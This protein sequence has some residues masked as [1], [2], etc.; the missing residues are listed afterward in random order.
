MRTFCLSPFVA[1]FFRFFAFAAG[2]LFCLAF[3]DA[4]HYRRFRTVPVYFRELIQAVTTSSARMCFTFT[5]FCTIYPSSQS[6]CHSFSEACSTPPNNCR[7]K[8]FRTF[9]YCINTY[10]CVARTC[11]RVCVRATRALLLITTVCAK[12]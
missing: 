6:R 12:P 7:W 1:Y 4:D 10:T 3:C 2:F 5:R 11:T 9:E 8:R